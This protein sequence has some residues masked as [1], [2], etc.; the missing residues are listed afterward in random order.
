MDVCTLDIDSMQYFCNAYLILGNRHKRISIVF[1]YAKDLVI[2]FGLYDAN[3]VKF[4]MDLN[5]CR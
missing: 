5:L 2:S 1:I 3:L 4:L